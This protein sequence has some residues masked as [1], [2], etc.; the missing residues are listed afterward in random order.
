[1][2]AQKPG[3][4]TAKKLLEE[5]IT[6]AK[7]IIS[8]ISKLK[9]QM[10]GRQEAS[11]SVF[12]WVTDNIYWKCSGTYRTIADDKEADVRIY[13]TELT[14]L[15]ENGQGSWFTAPWLYAE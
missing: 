1:M 8:A 9:Y 3:D 6:E 14:K 7:A 13:N 10:G 15:D 2:E 12:A 11:V 4:E 5:K